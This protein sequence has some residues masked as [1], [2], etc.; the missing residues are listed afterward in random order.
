MNILLTGGAGYIGSHTALSLIDKGHSVTVVDNLITGN[1]TLIPAKAK[2]YDF[3]IADE[4]SIQKILKENKFHMAMHFAGLT[5]VDE[6]IKY[7]EKYQLHNFEKSKIFFFSC[8]K[9]NLKNIIFSSSAGVYGNSNSGNLTEDS[10]LKP[11][12][13]Y[14]NS[15]YKIENL[16]IE[17]SKKEKLNYTILRYFNVAG[18]DKNNRSGLISKSS[19]NLIKVLCEVVNKK[20]EK[21][22]INGND[23]KTKDGT[24]VR[25]FIHV[26]DIAD[27]HVLAANNLLKNG[28]SNIYNC[29]YGNGYSVKEVI[30]EMENI[31][32]NKLQVEIGPRRP[33]D[34]AVSIANSDKF[35][36]EFNWKPRFNNLN[37]ILRSALEWEKIN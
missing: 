10:E 6:S 37:Y 8:I 25:D 16:L 14:A 18:A 3:D 7:P 19:S 5:R 12:N 4:S 1:K 33:N 32:K 20:R 2:Y 13:P 28:T 24:A 27:M 31:I 26:T 21:I 23:Y 11:I 9:N 29:G 34:I 22:I 36:K 35:K 30:A 17:I 15:K